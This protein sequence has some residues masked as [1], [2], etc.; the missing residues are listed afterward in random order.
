[1]NKFVPV[2][3]VAVVVLGG[4]FAVTMM[5]KDDAKDGISTAKTESTSDGKKT[6]AKFTDPCKVVTKAAVEAAF[7]FN[8]NEG[9]AEKDGV[10]SDDLPSKSCVFESVHED[11]VTGLSNATNLT[12]AFETYKDEASAK[13]SIEATKSSAKIGDKVYFVKTDVANVGDEAFFFQ[14][15]ASA[16]LKSEEFLYARKG[17]QVIHL[18]AVKLAG[19]D[20]TAA[21]QALTKLGSGSLN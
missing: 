13:A 21:Q 1:M 15:Q 3:I 16:V 5:A 6:E 20:H 19:I 17:N 2:A 18:I 9:K 11:T 8:F 10:T 4:G 12:V 14:N 7:G